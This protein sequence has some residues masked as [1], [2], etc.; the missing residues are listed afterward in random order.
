MKKK[1]FLNTKDLSEYLGVSVPTLQ[2]WRT[3]GDGVKYIKRGGIIL[4]DL[5]DVHDWVDEHKRYHSR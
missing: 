4:Y 1:E 5:D 2:R 3:T